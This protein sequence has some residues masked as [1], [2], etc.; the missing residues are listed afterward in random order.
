MKITVN[1]L[2]HT[3]IK[4]LC[5]LACLG[6]ALLPLAACAPTPAPSGMLPVPEETNRLTIY[7]SHKQEVYGP[8]IDEFELRTGIWVTVVTGGTNELLDRIA[9]EKNAPS[10]DVMF[11]G[12]AE[13][14]LAARD[15]FTPYA[16]GN[17]DR[18]N[19]NFRPKDGLYTPF[20]SLPLV[21]IY[22]TRLIS[23]DAIT[24]WEDLLNPAWQGKIAFADPEISGSSYTM[25]Y[26]LCQVM[27]GKPENTLS[28]FRSNIGSN[29]LSS[30]GAVVTAVA[31]GTLP[32]GIT[33]E[34]TAR[35]HIAQ[36]ESIAMVFPAEGTSAVPDGT[37]LV[38][39]A[40]HEEN[41]RLF[42]DFVLS[43]DV[44]ER[45]WDRQYRRSVLTG[46][47]MPQDMPSTEGLQLVSYD[48][49]SASEM[50][51]LLLTIFAECGKEGLS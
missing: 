43:N 45:L 32:V 48:M 24:G 8:V 31:D 9:S 41:A 40:P 20:S 29:L 42:L 11:G 2:P 44:Q 47:E 15:L 5:R 28:R 21:L 10:C 35:K 49:A 16:A 1:Q 18:I 17:A 39:G 6:M 3:I 14:L 4:G 33:L 51:P 13:N 26:T 27:G 36:G 50:K 19:P 38:H 23:P 25:L 22:N 34:E 30:S 12:G 46:M 37:A 7:T